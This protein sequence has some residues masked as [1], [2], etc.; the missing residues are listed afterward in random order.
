MPD[1]ISEY[2]WRIRAIMRGATA[3]LAINCRR[4]NGSGFIDGL[5]EGGEFG[6]QAS[7]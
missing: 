1:G 4:E 6:P 3:R 2:G 7:Q 5:Q